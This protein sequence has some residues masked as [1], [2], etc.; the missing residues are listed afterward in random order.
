MT[1]STL[2]DIVNGKN[3][4]QASFMAGDMRMKG[5]FKVLRALDQVLVFGTK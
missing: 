4:F 1:R 2:E 3:T 5:D